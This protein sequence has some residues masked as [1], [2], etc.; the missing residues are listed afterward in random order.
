[1][2]N[3]LVTLVAV[4]CA[5]GFVQFLGEFLFLEPPGFFAFYV[6]AGAA[7]LIYLIATGHV[8]VQTWRVF[9]DK[10]NIVRLVIVI[11]VAW[12]WPAFFL[13]ERYKDY[14][15]LQGA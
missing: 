3:I 5:A 6:T 14:K 8:M 10:R 15:A 4:F 7:A 13:W 11:L 1:M 12:T 2:K 9:H